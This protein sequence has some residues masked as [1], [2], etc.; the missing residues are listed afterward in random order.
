MS[1]D[2]DTMWYDWT[3]KS[4][5]ILGHC[6]MIVNSWMSKD[7][8]IMWYDCKLIMCKDIYHCYVTIN[9]LCLKLFTTMMM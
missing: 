9:S 8:R 6:D 4:L 5:R 3:H 1:K 7:T 2:S